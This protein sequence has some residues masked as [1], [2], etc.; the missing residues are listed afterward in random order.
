MKHIIT[1]TL[2]VHPNNNSSDAISPN[3][4][5][6]CYGGCEKTYCYMS[7]YNKGVNI[8]INVEDINEAVYN[9]V[10]NQKWPKTSNQQDNT[11]YVVD[12]G[13]DTDLSLMSKY[14]NLKDILFFYDTH[15]ML[16][17]TFA[18]KYPSKLLLDVNDFNKKPRVRISLM[19]QIYSTILEP[20]TDKIED[21][22]KDID[23]LQQLGWEVHINFS[24][25]IVYNGWLKEYETL[26]NMVKTS[27]YKDTKSE[28]IF[29]TNHENTMKKVNDEVK[30]I[31]KY[32]NEIKNNTGVMRYP[33][34]K[35][36]I[37]VNE[38]TKLHNK[39]LGTKI[40]YIF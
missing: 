14:I 22:I 33:I 23:R 24:P 3:Y 25:V 26:F 36:R 19:P 28:I 21:R 7:R 5:Y 32:S 31:I 34:N 4:I 20:N 1:K 6:G 29:L 38:I 17:S 10:E 18:T 12:I 9:W 11:Y 35:K 27:N 8:N 15:P 37:F 30:E 39:L 40:R 13:C 2:K 16:K